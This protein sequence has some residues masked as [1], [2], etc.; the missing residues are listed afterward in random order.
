MKKLRMLSAVF[1]LLTVPGKVGYHLFLQ[2]VHQHDGMRHE[3][4]IR[5]SN[6]IKSSMGF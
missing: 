5:L 6:A 2:N 3:R 4:I 1:V